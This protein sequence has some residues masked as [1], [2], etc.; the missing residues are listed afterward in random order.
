MQKYKF[1]NR[2][3]KNRT[4]K[5]KYNIPTKLHS[6]TKPNLTTKHNSTTK[7]KSISIKNNAN[8]T[9]AINDNKTVFKNN[10]TTVR[11][12]NSNGNNG[13]KISDNFIEE[14]S[15]ENNPQRQTN[16][17]NLVQKFIIASSVVI[18]ILLLF[19]FIKKYHSNKKDKNLAYSSSHIH[20]SKLNNGIKYTK[21][22][23]T[24]SNNSLLYIFKN[25]INN[26]GKQPSELTKIPSILKVPPEPLSSYLIEG[27][28]EKFVEGNT[29][30]RDISVNE[31]ILQ[32][33]PNNRNSLNF[34]DKTLSWHSKNQNLLDTNYIS[35]NN[36]D[37]NE[38]E[39][40]NYINS[41]N[42][43]D[44]LIE[45]YFS[46]KEKEIRRENS[47]GV[48]SCYPNIP[49]NASSCGEPSLSR[50]V[51]NDTLL[52]YESTR[53]KANMYNSKYDKKI[54][55]NYSTNINN[56]YSIYRGKR[57]ASLSSTTVPSLS[58]YNVKDISSSIA[59]RNN[60]EFNIRKNSIHCPNSNN[61]KYKFN[62]NFTNVNE[63]SN[64]LKNNPKKFSIK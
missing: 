58:R 24:K 63:E 27:T 16:L 31:S 59:S 48:N 30:D 61:M 18:F 42:K 26:T 55:N 23:L 34:F 28:P 60:N 57:N 13:N 7:Y 64:N 36:T 5:T 11:S 22:K 62:N 14:N 10:S 50:Y 40:N 53:S 17:V 2:I 56:D 25:K 15:P 21:K 1:N 52:K 51:D 43:F 44:N 9:T 47:D 38:T 12:N 6:T 4:K 54:E 29:L 8:S 45:I 3:N 41:S 35:N 46:N 19:C 39:S 49:D 33:Q 20:K 32:T 37:I